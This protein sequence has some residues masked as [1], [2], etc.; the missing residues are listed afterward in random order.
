M[1]LRF[2]ATWLAR[3]IMRAT[4]KAHLR[5]AAL[6]VV[7]VLG[8]YT[9]L[10]LRRPLGPEEVARRTVAAIEAGDADAIIALMSEDERKLSGVNAESLRRFL[11]IIG[12]PKSLG[13]TPMDQDH[14]E[15]FKTQSIFSLMRSYRTESGRDVEVVVRAIRTPEGFRSSDVLFSIYMLGLDLRR[16]NT[17]SEPESRL[18]LLTQN[19]E[20]SSGLLADLRQTGLK[21]LVISDYMDGKSRLLGWD[22]LDAFWQMKIDKASGKF[23]RVQP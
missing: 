3:E 21:G 22:E 8:T 6:L 15:W 5:W 17:P 4:K 23:K 2:H 7:L 9:L 11:A 14:T 16:T 12:A 18:G 19:R 10:S 13:L 1:A 20:S